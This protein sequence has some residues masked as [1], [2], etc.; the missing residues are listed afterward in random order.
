MLVQSIACGD[1]GLRDE[2][3][4]QAGVIWCISGDCR[5][6]LH[7]LQAQREMIDFAMLY[8]RNQIDI[9]NSHSDSYGESMSSASSQRDDEG[10]RSSAY[11]KCGWSNATSWQQFERNSAQHDRARSDSVTTS[12]AV[13]TATGWDRGTQAAQGWA[14]S[15]DNAVSRGDAQAT[16]TAR[17]SDVRNSTAGSGT[18]GWKGDGNVNPGDAGVDYTLPSF[19]LSL[20][21]PFISWSAGSVSIN[22]PVNDDY[23]NPGTKFPFCGDEDSPCEPLASYGRGWTANYTISFAIPSFHMDVSWNNGGNFRQSF[24]CS[25][26]RTSGN[27]LAWTEAAGTS[28]DSSESDGENTAHDE[29]STRHDAHRTA[30]N[31][32]D[33]A[34]NGSSSARSVMNS[35]GETDSGSDSAGHTEQS[36]TGTS[37]QRGTSSSQSASDTYDD[38][39]STSDARYWSQIFA[40]LNDMWQRV[41]NEIIQAEHIYLASAPALSGLL[42]ATISTPCCDGRVPS[43]MTVRPRATRINMPARANRCASGACS[44]GTLR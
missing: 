17:S 28:T 38:T 27:G 11:H 14:V 15:W 19:D 5:S 30:S 40:A 24:I 3:D 9:A 1:D 32:S 20:A 44:F 8:V 6:D 36:A 12:D 42:S 39:I 4:A 2:L 18:P 13:S 21:P 29:N 25:S 26:G 10:T 23:A 31:Y 33:G 22:D 37:A 7:Y 43:N 35:L 41:L 34:S 16:N